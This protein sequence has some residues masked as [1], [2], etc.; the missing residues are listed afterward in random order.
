MKVQRAQEIEERVQNILGNGNNL[1]IDRV[2]A[3][4]ENEYLFKN[5]EKELT[6]LHKDLWYFVNCLRERP[7]RVG[8]LSCKDHLEGE[9]QVKFFEDIRA[10][11]KETFPNLEMLKSEDSERTETTEPD[12]ALH[13]D[14]MDMADDESKCKS[15]VD[16]LFFHSDLCPTLRVS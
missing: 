3:S 11:K 2:T 15:Y 4:K 9:D 13:N 10:E 14:L 16:L 6:K 5:F 1:G 12:K 7:G 8:W